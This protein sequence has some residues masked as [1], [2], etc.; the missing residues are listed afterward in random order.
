MICLIFNLFQW[1]FETQCERARQSNLKL[2]AE[3]L[4]FEKLVSLSPRNPNKIPVAG[5]PGREPNMTMYARPMPAPG[6]GFAV[7]SKIRM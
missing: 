3:Y 6:E 5:K 1:S 7:A 4:S 2:R